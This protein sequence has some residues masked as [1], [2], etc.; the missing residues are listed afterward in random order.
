LVKSLE[1]LRERRDNIL[2]EIKKDEEKRRDIENYIKKL[3]IE[4]EGLN[5]IY[6]I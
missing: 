1:G 6:L 5:G 3:E 2:L 4:L